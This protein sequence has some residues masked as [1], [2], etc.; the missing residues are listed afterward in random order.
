MEQVPCKAR[1]LQMNLLLGKLYRCS[2]NNR[3]AVTCYK[4]CLR[5]VSKFLYLYFPNF[6]FY[7]L[8]TFKKPIHLLFSF[9]FSKKKNSPIEYSFSI[10]GYSNSIQ[11]LFLISS[12]IM[13]ISISFTYISNMQIANICIIFLKR[14]SS[15][16]LAQASFLDASLK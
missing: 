10:F 9:F 12:L 1:N 4:E 15:I 8:N 2:R 6:C 14:H 11:I 3:C 13:K 5:F 16:T 7:S